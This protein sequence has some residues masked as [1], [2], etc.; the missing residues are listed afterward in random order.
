MHAVNSTCF[1]RAGGFPKGGNARPLVGW[2][3]PGGN[4]NPPGRLSFGDAKPRFL[5]RDKGNGVLEKRSLLGTDKI[6]LYQYVVC[7][8]SPSPA[9][10][11]LPDAGRGKKNVQL[12]TTLSVVAS[13]NRVQG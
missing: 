1:L 13:H 9:V 6:V 2:G 10:T 4:R 8:P 5:W 7:G 11:P 3:G 12:T